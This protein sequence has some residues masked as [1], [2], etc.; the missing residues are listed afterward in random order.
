[1]T[2][3]SDQH[4]ER[5]QSEWKQKTY[6][7][8][9]GHESGAGRLF[10]VVLI[11]AII[12]SV[13]VVMLDSVARV[14]AEQGQLLFVLEWIFTILFT[15]EYVLRLTVSPNP[16]AYARSF[17]GMV[18]LFSILPTYL[19][20]ILPGGQ[21]LIVIRLL[22]VLRVFRVL[23]L[24]QYVGEAN[25]LG[26][27]FWEQRY[28]ITVFLFTVLTVVAIVG[29]LMYLIEGPEAGFTS[30]P[31]GVYWAIVTLTTVGY[32][33]IA[34]TT[35]LGQALAAMVMILGYGIIAVPTSIVTAGLVNRSHAARQDRRCA[36]C[37][38]PGHDSDATHCNHC[39]THLDQATAPT[40]PPTEPISDSDPSDN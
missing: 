35:S 2:A 29:S 7:V 33:D 31:R 38:Q 17:F 15:A 9:F 25:V 13:T 21:F 39:G 24:T 28:K 11:F 1:M 8:I 22:R 23:K 12:A 36:N 4:T 16:R 20:L 32:G 40:P 27:T 5:P 18:D 14:R 30:I 6:D 37:G 3:E 34:P 10:D 19:S 26:Q